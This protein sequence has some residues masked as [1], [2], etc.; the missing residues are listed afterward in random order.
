MLV[1][2]FAFD[3]EKKKKLNFFK[4][5]CFFS[6]SVEISLHLL[7]L[8][9]IKN[10]LPFST[11]LLCQ[12]K[13]QKYFLIWNLFYLIDS[14]KNIKKIIYK[15]IFT[16]SIDQ[17]TYLTICINFRKRYK[18]DQYQVLYKTIVAQLLVNAFSLFK[19]PLW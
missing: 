11:W 14:T 10:K 13:N 4:R 8:L 7:N 19:N 6:S 12:L 16:Q 18:F 5:N 3:E 17:L 1:Y 9:S 15:L 2:E